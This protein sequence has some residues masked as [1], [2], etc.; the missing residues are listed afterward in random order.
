VASCGYHLSGNKNTLPVEM[1]TIAVPMV[2]NRSFE[3]ALEGVVTRMI[4]ESF[5]T[6]SRLRVSESPSGADLLLT[7]TILNFELIPL[8]FDRERNVVLEYRVRIELEIQLKD[9]STGKVLWKDPFIEV[10]AEFSVTEDTT[11]S[12]VA[13]DRA[14]QEASQNLGDDL[15]NRVLEGTFQ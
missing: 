5:L 8:S 3:P 4:R 9:Q 14:I 15:V 2:E 7:G 13:E 11:S 6:N 10:T 12:R 1:E